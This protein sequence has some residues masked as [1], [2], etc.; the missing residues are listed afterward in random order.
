MLVNIHL[1]L[2]Y[3]F[4]ESS[5]AKNIVLILHV[6]SFIFKGEFLGT[7]TNAERQFVCIYLKYTLWVSGILAPGEE[8]GTYRIRKYY[9]LKGK[10]N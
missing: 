5:L 10:F 9:Y 1:S 4:G 6:R 3:L 2:F 7:E 8:Y